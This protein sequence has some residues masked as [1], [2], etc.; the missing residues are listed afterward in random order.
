MRAQ[1]T[2]ESAGNDGA[3]TPRVPPQN[4][5]AESA[6]LGA[7]L[8][9]PAVSMQVFDRLRP[10]HFYSRRNQLIY[11]A[12][13]RLHDDTGNVDLLLLR[14]RLEREG[15]L[16]EVGGL[17]YLLALSEAV[18]SS[19]H[20]EHYRDI[21][22]DRA[23]LRR[24]I[25]TCTEIVQDAAHDTAEAR[26]Q[27]ERAEQ[28][29]FELSNNTKDSEIVTSSD[30]VK[31]TF[32]LIDQWSKGFTGLPTGYMDLDKITNGLQPSELIVVA[33]RPSMGK[34]TLCLNIAQNVA[35][36]QKKPVLI[37]SLEVDSRQLAMN[38][39]CGI[40]RVES[41]KLRGNTL[42]QRDWQRLLTA[43]DQ[44]SSAP[45][46]F[47]DSVNLTTLSIRARARRCKEKYGIGLIV[48]DYLQM[49]EHGGGQQ[50]SRQQEISAIS[51][52]LKSMARELKIPVV[53]VSQLSR[54]V[55][56]REDHRP[57]MSDLRESGAIEQD[58]DLILL[59]YRDEYYHPDR[60]E[61]KG[62]AEVIIAKHR[63]GPVGTVNL[64]FIG[65]YMRFE[66]WAG[67]SN[68]EL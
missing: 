59:I 31:N 40:A 46:F 26:A 47:D 43:A 17:E 10:E 60:E 16:E 53:T 48:I 25:D 9:A 65:E 34:T 8:L 58:A 30:A 4:L 36:Q 11:E 3:S 38:L 55:E 15:L 19:A 45:M 22:I 23:L 61:S 68:D 21:V 64:A 14:D 39:L 50:E 62:R 51:R 5:S 37:F 49:L 29:I 1:T 2:R 56:Q 57:R 44:L 66:S 7:V 33:G 63:N 54:A 42:G 32:D 41:E 18:S 6:V 27:V 35:L 20:T 12:M 28:R 24:L 13:I 52:M 67:P